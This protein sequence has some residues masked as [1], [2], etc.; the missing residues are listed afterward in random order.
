M[1]FETLC[2]KVGD[3]FNIG[4]KLAFISGRNCLMW[5]MARSVLEG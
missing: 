1:V 5:L 3:R 4:L 2:Y